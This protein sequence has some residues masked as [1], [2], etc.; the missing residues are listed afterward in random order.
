[1]KKQ[2]KGDSF[3]VP[4]VSNAV[5]KARPSRQRHISSSMRVID[6]EVREGVKR[7]KLEMLEADNY[8]DDPTGLSA[9]AVGKDDSDDDLYGSS[10]FGKSSKQKGKS[11][12][13]SDGS[14]SKFTMGNQRKK[15]ASSQTRKRRV[16]EILSTDL[17]VD[18]SSVA[19]DFLD[20]VSLKHILSSVQEKSKEKNGDLKTISRAMQYLKARSPSSRYPPRYSCNGCGAQ[21]LG[22]CVRCGTR[23][24]GAACMAA[25][26][27]SVCMQFG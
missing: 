6:E 3:G 7:T 15:L 16:A 25:H 17:S 1:M 8:D 27:E 22:S 2:Q 26:K 13:N 24:C 5:E 10:S 12:S 18:I 9:D 20:P 19:N 11:L 4:N 23:I 14:S 21:A